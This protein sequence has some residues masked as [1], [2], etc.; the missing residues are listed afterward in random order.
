[1]VVDRKLE[2]VIAIEVED[3]IV[4]ERLI[5]AMFRNSTYPGDGVASR[6]QRLQASLRLKGVKAGK[7]PL[8]TVCEALAHEMVVTLLN[9][10]CSGESSCRLSLMSWL[11]KS[12]EC[13]SSSACKDG[14]GN[15]HCSIEA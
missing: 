2:A 8:T 15:V 3:L 6:D 4:R 11:H 9:A 13:T 14:C 5:A 1:L 10:N 12:E 7:N